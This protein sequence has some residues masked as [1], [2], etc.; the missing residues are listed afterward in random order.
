MELE[1]AASTY[2]AAWHHSL[3]DPKHYIHEHIHFHPG[4]PK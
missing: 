4:F 1:A 2:Q 3:A